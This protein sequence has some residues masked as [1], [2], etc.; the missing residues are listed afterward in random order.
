MA[1]RTNR[2]RKG[3]NPVATDADKAKTSAAK[4]KRSVV[5]KD[6][7]VASDIATQSLSVSAPRKSV[8]L[9]SAAIGG[10]IVGTWIA[11]GLGTLLGAFLGPMIAGATDE[12][13][14][15]LLAKLGEF[16]EDGDDQ[17]GGDEK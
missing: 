4:K 10:A 2:R 9:G 14:K 5:R 13:G 6:A 12:N 1:A 7:E 3:A 11:P 16:F 15:G 17:N 8:N